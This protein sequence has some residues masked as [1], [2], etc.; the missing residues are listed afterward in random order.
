M[1][2]RSLRREISADLGRACRCAARITTSSPP[3]LASRAP[4]LDSTSRA[5]QAHC[6]MKW[7]LKIALDL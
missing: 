3:L 5:S 6:H 4:D 2:Q 1:L 7:V